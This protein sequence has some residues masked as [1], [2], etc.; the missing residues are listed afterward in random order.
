VSDNQAG[1]GGGISFNSGE[2]IIRDSVIA[3][4][5][6]ARVGGGL[7]VWAAR[8]LLIEASAID[9]NVLEGAGAEH[10]GG[11]LIK[12]S[13]ATLWASSVQRNAAPSGGGI[14]GQGQ[15]VIA[16]EAG[17]VS[18]NV[19]AVYGGGIVS[20]ST[21]ILAINTTT[22]N[23]NG[24]TGAGGAIYN[25]GD[26]FL[27]RS[28]LMHNVSGTSGGGLLNTGVA[29]VDHTTFS[30]NR[31]VAGAA[32]EQIAGA[33]L[34]LLNSTLAD[35]YATDQGGGIRDAS[36]RLTIKNTFI[37][38]NIAE[39]SGS[40]CALG[41]TAPAISFSLWN[42]ASCGTQTGAGNHPNVGSVGLQVL[43]MNGGPTLT[44]GLESFSP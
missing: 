6:A 29:E 23:D 19:A 14:Y 42:D 28:T 30:T 35:N 7:E 18:H 36:D 33:A 41:A 26:L 16:I 31:A 8:P 40:N 27:T 34:T 38:Y 4:N 37:A 24:S 2:L 5:R 1:S 9:D 22:M 15:S 20:E 43:R 21:A 17:Q 32:I 13:A 39:V 44:Y 11:L 25:S 3:G 12:D 10:G